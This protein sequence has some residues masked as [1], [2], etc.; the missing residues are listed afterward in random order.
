MTRTNRLLVIWCGIYFALLVVGCSSEVEFTGPSGPEAPRQDAEA[1]PETPVP[2]Q[3]AVDPETPV[4][5]PTE[6]PVVPPVVPVP[7]EKVFKTVMVER[8]FKPVTVDDVAAAYNPEY[9]YLDQAVTLKEQPPMKISTRQLDRAGSRESFQQ[10]RAAQRAEPE[11]FSITEAGKLD[12]LVVVDDS[13]SMDSEIVNLASKLDPLISKL[14]NTDWQIAVVT[15]SDPCLRDNRLIKKGDAD[16]N[17]A[18]AKAIGDIVLSN[19]VIEK[20][21]P[22]SIKALKGECK[23]A[24]S[25][26]ARTNAAIGILILSD[27]DNCGSHAGEGCPGE[28][29]ET[30]VQMTDYL[31]SIRSAD[32][33]RIYGIFEGAN[34][35]GNSAYTATK[36]KQGVD[37]TGGKWGSICQNDYSTTLGQISEDVRKLVK[38]EFTLKYPPESG[39]LMLTIDG[40]AKTSGYTINGNVL[41][42][43][44]LAATD[45]M[46]TVNYFYGAIPKAKVFK[47]TGNPDPAT[48][49]VT[50]NDVAVNASDLSFDPILKDIAFVNEPV[51]NAVIKIAY[52]QNTPL[53][54][55]FSVAGSDILGAPQKVT[56]ENVMASNYSYDVNAMKVVFDQAPADGKNVEIFF[57][58]KSGRIT[59]YA[60]ALANLATARSISVVDRLTGTPVAVATELNDLVFAADEILDGRILDVKFDIGYK[61]EDLVFRLAYQPLSGSLKI[62]ISDPTCEKN[63]LTSGLDIQVECGAGKA[64]IIS[65]SY[66]AITAVDTEFKVDAVTPADAVWQVFVDESEIMSPVRTDQVITIAEDSFAEGSKVR[67][68][69]TWK[70]EVDPDSL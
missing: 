30:V 46:L 2:D 65:L 24:V 6:P 39:T 27:E 37:Q 68:V 12:L 51:D 64:G 35:C 53:P 29:G 69:V 58:T 15:T 47:V 4:E 5:T 26:W 60:A 54:V 62:G 49:V 42:I 32:Q 36:Y 13:T 45:Q 38:R 14:E 21:F 70:E 50:V 28:Q 41:T 16:R 57:R 22:M 66:R 18:F 61:P 52:K 59:R 44:G 55:E 43:T 33:G 34:E 40:V 17:A 31:R 3:P 25:P 20:G 9:Q 10:G 1:N 67:I 48:L 7:K 11:T 8:E 63:I 56:V 23:G 19:T